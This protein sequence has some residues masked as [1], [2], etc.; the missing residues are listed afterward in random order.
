MSESQLP[1]STSV[2]D[3]FLEAFGRLFGNTGNAAQTPVIRAHSWTVDFYP[4]PD[5]D[6]HVNLF[7]TPSS[8]IE[9]GPFTEDDALAVF[10][11]LT[12]PRR[13]WFEDLERAIDEYDWM[14]APE[15]PAQRSPVANDLAALLTAVG[16]FALTHDGRVDALFL[17]HCLE[18]LRRVLLPILDL[19]GGDPTAAWQM[20]LT[21]LQQADPQAL[22]VATEQFKSR[23][24]QVG[25]VRL[26]M[27][28]QLRNLGLARI[29]GVDSGTNRL[30]VEPGPRTPIQLLWFML[31]TSIGSIV[32]P[33]PL[34]GVY[35]CSYHRCQQLFLTRKIGVTGTR[36]FCS[37]EHGKRFYAARR[38][39]EKKLG[40]RY[41]VLDTPTKEG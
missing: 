15:E 41:P 17:V 38:M 28:V 30:I 29:Q 16:D 3:A 10:S 6:G 5:N 40:T 7:A 23:D 32:P 21:A 27:G 31:A 37:I 26:A 12:D 22:S 13:D 24:Q 20:L 2:G 34:S 39:R 25:L 1:N 14:P 18:Q 33:F 11:W 8:P 35:R 36:R 4:D 9:S 19:S